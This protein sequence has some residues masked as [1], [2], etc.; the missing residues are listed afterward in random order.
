MN[1]LKDLTL[2]DIEEKIYN[3]LPSAQDIEQEA[4]DY[5]RDSS[6]D[7]SS[8]GLKE[9]QNVFLAR[10]K[11]VSAI[12]RFV[13]VSMIP[14]IKEIIDVFSKTNLPSLKSNYLT[15]VFSFLSPMK[16]HDRNLKET[17]K[18]YSKLL[19]KRDAYNALLELFSNIQKDQIY[20]LERIDKKILLGKSVFHNLSNNPRKPDE[21]LSELQTRILQ[22]ELTK[23][24]PLQIITKIQSAEEIVNSILEYIDNN[25]SPD[26]FL[27]LNN[28]QEALVAAHKKDEVENY[29][30]LL[31][32]YQNIL[33]DIKNLE[34][35]DED[36]EEKF[37]DLRNSLPLLLK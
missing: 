29:E 3:K 23:N 25:L 11:A 2:I 6:E 26:F 18:I 21:K 10:E 30:K 20:L 9:E 17:E 1:T 5:I 12:K 22:M 31:S 4:L 37:H 13:L 28:Y 32:L 35:L 19:K 8:F 7:I 34:I 24:I 16:Q 36:L 27:Y 15:Y 14:L 33:R